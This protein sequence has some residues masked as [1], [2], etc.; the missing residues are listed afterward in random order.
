MPGL[1][2]GC[3]WRHLGVG[4]LFSESAQAVEAGDVFP[5]KHSSGKYVSVMPH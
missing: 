3:G 1:A 5:Q 2:C 4:S